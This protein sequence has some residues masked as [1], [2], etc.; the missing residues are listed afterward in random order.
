MPTLT[1]EKIA[2]THFRRQFLFQLL[3]LLNHMLTFTKSA[4]TT[5]ATP[6]NRSLQMDFT[7]EPEDAQWVQETLSKAM[8]EL[9][10]TTPNGRAFAE[11]VQTILEREKNWVKWKNELCAP[12]DKT[13]WSTTIDGEKVGL[14]QATKDLRGQ[15]RKPRENWPYLLGTEPLT[16][17]WEMG[18][19][20][21]DDLENLFQLSASCPQLNPL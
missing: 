14:F 21:L 3:I 1:Y 13:T 8:E 20:G 15:M 6:R 9:K 2:D 18:Y 7:L 5:W 19:R 4:K 17:I 11:T 12:F 10:Q 16:E